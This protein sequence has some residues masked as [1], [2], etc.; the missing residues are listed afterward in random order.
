MD[1]GGFEPGTSRTGAPS[2]SRPGGEAEG[3]SS[4]GRRGGHAAGAARNNGIGVRV[5]AKIP[6]YS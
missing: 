2:T 1:R 5:R 6:Q 4:S 3:V